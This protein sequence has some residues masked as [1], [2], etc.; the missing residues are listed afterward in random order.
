MILFSVGLPGRLADW[1]DAV[2]AHLATALGGRVSVTTWPPVGNMLGYHEVTPMLDHI[3][4]SLL[5]DDATHLVVGARQ[6]DER[7]RAAL[8]S[9]GA[10]FVVALDDPRAAVTDILG[11]IG[12]DLKVATRAIANSCPYV[13]QYASSPGALVIRRNYA[14]LTGAEAVAAI[15][16]HFEFRL[17]D[18]QAQRI[19]NE[20]EARGL[21]YASAPHE[22]PTTV[23]KLVDGALAGYAEWFAGGDLSQIIWQ[24]ELFAVNTDGGSGLAEALD[25]RGGIR[26]LIFGPYI[27]VPA[28]SWLARV[29]LGFSLEAAGHSFYVDV[30]SGGQVALA[31]RIFQPM[32]AGV[33]TVDIDFS[34]DEPAGLGLEVRVFVWSDIA[35][36]QLAFGHVLLRPLAMRQPEVIAGSQEDFRTVLDI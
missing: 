11:A 7:L 17:I 14:D 5:G 1:C 34:I 13:M 23:H 3:A 9:E 30:Y 25:L 18:D 33:Y 21:R 12:G 29:V 4:L 10:R 32:K 28:G 8:V 15:A 6:P 2:L 36:G 20:L 16:R 26:T 22:N 24:R 19:V 31:H 35:R 27:H